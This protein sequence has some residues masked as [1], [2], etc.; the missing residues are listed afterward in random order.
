MIFRNIRYWWRRRRHLKILRKLPPG[1]WAKEVKR[2]FP[3]E[4]SPFMA[5]TKMMDKVPKDDPEF[6]C[7]HSI[8][9]ERKE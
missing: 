1:E 4:E 8:L 3:D 5:L 7:F 2:L 6:K 9:G